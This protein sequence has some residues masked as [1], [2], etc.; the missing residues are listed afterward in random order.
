MKRKIKNQKKNAQNQRKSSSGN[1]SLDQNSVVDEPDQSKVL[2]SGSVLGK[3]R[4]THSTVQPPQQQKQD[5]NEKKE[6]KSQKN[7]E[8]QPQKAILNLGGDQNSYQMQQ[9][10]HL[11]TIE[12]ERKYKQNK[13]LR[14]Q[15]EKQKKELD[16]EAQFWQEQK[17]KPSATGQGSKKVGRPGKNQEQAEDD[18]LES[19]YE[20]DKGAGS[21]YN[22]KNAID[23]R[24]EDAE[25]EKILRDY[26]NESRQGKKKRDFFLDRQLDLA[27]YKGIQ[28]PQHLKWVSIHT[29]INQSSSQSLQKQNESVLL[30]EIHALDLE[31]KRLKELKAMHKEF[32]RYVEMPSNIQRFYQLQSVSCLVPANAAKAGVRK[33]ITALMNIAKSLA[34]NKRKQWDSLN[35]QRN[36]SFNSKFKVVISNFANT[37]IVLMS[38]LSKIQQ[39]NNGSGDG[40]FFLQGSTNPIDQTL[41]HQQTLNYLNLIGAGSAYSTTNI[42]FPMVDERNKRGRPPKKP[43]PVE[44][45]DNKEKQGQISNP[46]MIKSSIPTNQI[47]TNQGTSVIQ[48]DQGQIQQNNQGQQLENLVKNETN[49]EEN[50]TIV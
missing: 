5:K 30:Q 4:A 9:E 16:E 32:R 47:Q 31:I 34:K 41:L 1:E 38:T 10:E 6:A 48:A 12:R 44:N 21:R 25:L 42:I 39:K 29:V 22:E 18:D 46:D 28:L 2:S 15:K 33:N 23:M 37:L 17:G 49:F 45:T 14:E 40:G 8:P 43:K 20:N 27:Y 7:Q 50:K 13:K 26:N 35:L 19:D 24:R 36:Q 11:K 3:R